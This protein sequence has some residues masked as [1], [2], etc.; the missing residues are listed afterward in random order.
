[1]RFILA[2]LFS[3]LACVP[4]FAHAAR[5]LEGRWEGR[6]DIPGR[7]LP[8]IV[9]LAP[10]DAGRWTGSIV[11]PGL[12]IKGA[13]LAN[14]AVTETELSF[15]L[16]N[17]LASPTRGPAAFKAQLQTPDRIA[18]E[19]RQAGNV[20]PFAL[21]KRGPAQV[22]PPPRSTPVARELATQWTGEFELTGY[23]RHVTLTLENRGDAGAQANFVIVGKRTTDVPVDLVVQEGSLFRFESRAM[24]IVFEGRVKGDAAEIGG[25]IEL[26]PFELPLVLRRA[27]RGS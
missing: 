19:M 15:D 22:D 1:M 26:G 5:A 11:I 3:L 2:A 9:D 17:V 8:L 21:T 12:G 25:T 27:G 24:Q 7:E 13:A 23:P 16:G 10:T 20:A 18:G 14:L 6:V 4:G